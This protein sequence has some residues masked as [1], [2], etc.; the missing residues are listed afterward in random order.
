M[1]VARIGHLNLA[2]ILLQT[3]KIDVSLHDVNDTTALYLAARDDHY[4]VIQLLLGATTNS[5]IV[6]FPPRAVAFEVRS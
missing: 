6:D 2:E 5:D 3:P 4:E 1:L